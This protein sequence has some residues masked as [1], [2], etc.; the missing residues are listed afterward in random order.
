MTFR[1]YIKTKFPID[2]I[3]DDIVSDPVTAVMENDDLPCDAI[4]VIDG[5]LQKAIELS[6]GT[7]MSVINLLSYTKEDVEKMTDEDFKKVYQSYMDNIEIES[8]TIESI[9]SSVRNIRLH[10]EAQ[11]ELLNRCTD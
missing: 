3:I 1:D 2:K 7:Y 4:C 11:E 9:M 10:R 6:D 8:Y 5:V